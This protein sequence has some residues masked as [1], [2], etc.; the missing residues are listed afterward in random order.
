MTKKYFNWEKEWEGEIDPGHRKSTAEHYREYA[1][2]LKLMFGDEIN[3][4]LEIGCG[5]GALFPYLDFENKNYLGVDFSTSML[6]NFT[7]KYPKIKLVNHEGSSYLDGDS[8]DLIFSNGVIQYFD[9]VML[10]KHINNVSKMMHENS[11]FVCAS[12]PWKALRLNYLSGEM[13]LDSKKTYVRGIYRKILFSLKGDPIG[14]WFE[15]KNLQK[16]ASK[17]NMRMRLYG[18]MLYPYRFHAVLRKNRKQ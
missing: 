9:E 8:Y 5:N 3:S 2:E 6:N 11:L 12:I 4:I 15:P 7:D 14:N 1:Y 18:S 17:Y 13:N 16:L 10:E